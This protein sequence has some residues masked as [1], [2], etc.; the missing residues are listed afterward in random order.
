MNSFVQASDFD[1]IP[2]NIPNLDKMPNVFA[3]Y[4]AEQQELIL[5]SLLGASLY[6]S[7][8]EGLNTDY[9]TDRWRLLRDGDTY[10]YNYK[11]YTWVGMN[12][13]IRPYI[14]SMWL[15][16]TFDSH[17]GIGVV[18]GKGEN[19]KVINPGNRIARAWNKF[20]DITGD[21]C[22]NKNTLY[23]YL[24]VTGAVGTFDDSFDDSFEKFSLYFDFVFQAPGYMNTHNL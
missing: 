18:V 9:P 1:L 17:S 20:A 12:A 3:P 4:V 22:H 21:S 23:G 2:F 19:V 7:F 15:R 13:M 11:T 10:V 5:K 8:E 6:E 24:S 14:Y 16:D